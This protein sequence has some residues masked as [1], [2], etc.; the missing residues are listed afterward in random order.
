MAKISIIPNTIKAQNEYGHSY[1]SEHIL[2]TEEHINALK[3]G[4]QLAFCD[5]E[6]SNFLSMSKPK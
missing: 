6:Y 1:G 3:E 2:I 4:K 5:D